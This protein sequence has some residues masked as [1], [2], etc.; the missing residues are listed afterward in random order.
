VASTK[1]IE[2]K[3]SDIDQYAVIGQPIDHSYSPFIHGMFAKQTKQKLVY[4]KLEVSPQNLAAA[5]PRF[6]AENGKGMNVTIPHKQAIM[7]LCNYRTPRAELAGAV[8][9]LVLQDNGQLLGDNT[10][11]VGLVNDLVKN[12][13]FGLREAK[14]L[15]LG[16]G[17]AVRGVIAPLLTQAP[18]SIFIANRD[19]A[20]AVKL[21]EEFHTLGVMGAG[22]YEDI[23]GEFHL[24]ING[25]AASLQGTVPPIP[26]NCI[27]TDT[28]CYDMAYSKADT[29]FTRWAKDNGAGRAEL[30]WGMLVEQAAESFQLWRGVR[31]DTAPVLKAVKSPTPKLK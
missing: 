18:D 14:I 31:P 25:T 17:G 19:A 23:V 13:G 6:F 21:A 3:A 30:G 28:L 26:E 27:S 11:G 5:V 29:A 24:V 22:G 8:N 16:A 4:R 15:L 1:L 10:D 9:T 2:M 20:K 12:L 7:A